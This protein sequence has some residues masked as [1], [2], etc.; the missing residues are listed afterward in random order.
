MRVRLNAAKSNSIFS[1][2]LRERFATSSRQV[3]EVAHAI[4]KAIAVAKVV[5]CRRR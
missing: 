5:L 2:A 4:S 3:L 1:T